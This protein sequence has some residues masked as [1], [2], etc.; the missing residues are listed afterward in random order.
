RD[1]AEATAILGAE[2]GELGALSKA[3]LANGHQ[4]LLGVPGEGDHADDFVAL[5]KID[6]AHAAG[7][8]AHRADLIFLE[9]SGHALL[10]ADHDVHV[11]LRQAHIDE[12]VT[13]VDTDRAN[14]AR[15]NAVEGGGI[16]LLDR[17]VAG[18]HE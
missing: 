13:L 6:A 8:A 4:R 14:T 12:P 3:A 11:G 9:A 10:G 18:G 5:A 15:A 7:I 16:G 2:L 17:A 1:H